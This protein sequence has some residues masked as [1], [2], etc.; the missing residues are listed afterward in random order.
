MTF[1]TLGSVQVTHIGTYDAS[2]S[3]NYEIGAQLNSPVTA[4]SITFAVGAISFSAA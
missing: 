3:G 4:A 1:S 2:T